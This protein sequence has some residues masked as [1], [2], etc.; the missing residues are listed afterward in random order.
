MP[1]S[2]TAVWHRVGCCACDDAPAAWCH[3]AGR[4]GAAVLRHTA[5]SP[6]PLH[7]VYERAVPKMCA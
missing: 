5:F 4:D 6:T 2:H 7:R 3:P 1:D